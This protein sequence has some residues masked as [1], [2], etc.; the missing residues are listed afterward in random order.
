MSQI[1]DR[2]RIFIVMG[3]SGS[4]KSSVACHVARALDAALIDGDFL[5]PRANILKMESGIP[6]SDDDR[7]PWL[8]AVSD[9]A[10]AMQRSNRCSI[11][12]CSALKRRYRDRLRVGNPGLQFIYLHGTSDVIAE[13]LALRSGHFFKSELLRSQFEALEE[14]SDE[15]ADV[16]R[17]DIAKPLGEV[18]SE[19]VELVLKLSARS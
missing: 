4:G 3:V 5:H 11:M 14:P 13:R 15:E 8:A 17:I 2:H 16:H 12:V 18:V 1:Q 10:F 19:V 7:A 6:L 9:A